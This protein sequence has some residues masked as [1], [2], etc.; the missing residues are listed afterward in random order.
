[1]LARVLL[2][3][4]RAKEIHYQLKHAAL[5]HSEYLTKYQGIV[6]IVK[7]SLS[8]LFDSMIPGTKARHID[9]FTRVTQ[10]TICTH[11]SKSK[12]CQRRASL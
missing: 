1:M 3:I 2:F 9:T 8:I 6:N 11:F 7:R 5:Y 4:T 12:I 10:L